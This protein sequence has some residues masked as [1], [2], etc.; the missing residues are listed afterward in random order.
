MLTELSIEDMYVYYAVAAVHA[1]ATFKSTRLLL[2]CHYELPIGISHCTK[3]SPY[4]ASMRE[5]ESLSR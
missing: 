2:K 5:L 1:T 3:Q 4:L